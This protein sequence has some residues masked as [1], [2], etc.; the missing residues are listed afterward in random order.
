MGGFW[1]RPRD[2]WDETHSA[3]FELRRHFFLRFFYS[4]LVST[5]GQWQ[6]VAGGALGILLSLGLV[7]T[8]AYYHKYI[9]LNKLPIPEPQQL[10]TLADVL[11]LITL[12]MFLIG[13]FTTLQWPS[14]FPGLRDYLALGALPIRMREIFVA[15]FSAL[16]AFAGLFVVAVTL[17][18]SLI[19]P[20]VMSGRYAP[21]SLRQ[22]PAIFVSS[23]LAALFVFFSLVAV[24]GVLLNL[25]PIRQFSRISLTVQAALLTG[26]LCGLPLAFSIPSLQ[27]SMDQRPDWLVWVPPAWFLGLDQVMV[28]NREPMAERLAWISGAAFAGSACAALI[29]YLWSYRRHRVRM[30]ETPGVAATT[31]NGWLSAI[32]GRLIPDSRELAVFAFIAKTL[33]RSRQ[34]RLLLT[35]F[36]AVAVAVIFESFVSLALSRNFRG[37]SVPTTALR[38]AAISAPLALSLFV[39]AGFRYLFRLPV[40]LRANWVFRLNEPGNRMAFLA[41]VERFLLYCAVAPVALIT[42][43]IE[44]SL[45]GPRAG[46]AAAILCLLLS[47]ALME[48]LLI[49]FDKIP[50][51]SSYLPGRRPVIETVMIYVASLGLYVFALSGIVNWCLQSLVSA[52]ALLGILLAV[53]LTMRKGRMENWEAGQ[54]EFEELPEVAVLRLAIERD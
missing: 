37:F 25:M 9:E 26:L 46:A 1:Q 39:L 30:L 42:L 43:P 52:L 18:P 49:Q 54:I 47:L 22:V 50:F 4:D 14:L 10:A 11:F 53:W 21:D 51:T 27:R 35:A 6:V 34:H 19:L 16:L 32:A 7:F 23:S 3:A 44:V 15:K 40:E 45:L 20:A 28:G 48:L 41:A 29:T 2:W 5:P 13:L 31:R 33:A 36:A 8:Q 24:Q 12:A 38:Q 17:L